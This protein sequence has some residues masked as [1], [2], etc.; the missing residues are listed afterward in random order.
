MMQAGDAEHGMVNTIALQA[1]VAKDLPG[2]HAGEDVLDTGPD[3]TVGSVVLLL[4]GGK[5]V[6][7][8][9]PAVRDGQTRASVSTVGDDNGPS[10]SG[11]GSGQF[12]FLAVVPVTGQGPAATTSRVSASITTW[13]LVEYR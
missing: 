7:T 3:S 6:L 11:F 8:A 10:D 13:W 9:L 2:L 12:P 5:F 4:P 1:A